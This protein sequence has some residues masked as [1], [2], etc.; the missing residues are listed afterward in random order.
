MSMSIRYWGRRL[1]AVGCVAWL[2]GCG[3]SSS[4][5]SPS[6]PT[7]APTPAPVKTLVT[8]GSSANL[9]VHHVRVVR[10]TT[11]ATG[12]IETTVDWTLSTD[13]MRVVVA[14]GNDACFDGTFIDFSICNKVSDIAGASKPTRA[15]LPGQPAGAYTLYIDNLGPNVEAVSWQV[16]VTIPG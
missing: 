5:S 6:T 7:P 3:G 13:T 8:Q 9:A 11:T 10:F 12:R 14:T 1:A 15:S 16:F 2:A 4:P